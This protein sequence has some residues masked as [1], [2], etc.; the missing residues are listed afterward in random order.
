MRSE[1]S[2]GHTGRSSSPAWRVFGRGYTA[3]PQAKVP[4]DPKELPRLLVLFKRNNFHFSAELFSL[5][6]YL[7][8]HMKHLTV[9]ACS[10]EPLGLSLT[11]YYSMVQNDLD[12]S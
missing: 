10:L 6:F 12:L 11:V 5:V 8:E 9:R 2:L 4:V 1:G 3:S 7:L